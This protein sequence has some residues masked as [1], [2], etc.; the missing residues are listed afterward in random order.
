MSA[1]RA[2]ILAAGLHLAAASGAEPLEDLVWERRVLV[3]IAP[4]S[5]DPRVV[6][7][8]RRLDARACEVAERD[9]AT[10]LA[11]AMG[12]GRIDGRLLARAEVDKL[13]TRFRVGA[14]DFTVVLVGKDGGEKLRLAE[15]PALD[16]IF[17]LIDG[18]PM[19]RAEMHARKPAC[20]G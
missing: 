19:R 8:G 4:V 12:E 13:R 15:P 17:A 10:V 18:M 5:D 9:L 1:A 3:I 20:G 6:E 11:P 7:T 14:G 2:A 16:E